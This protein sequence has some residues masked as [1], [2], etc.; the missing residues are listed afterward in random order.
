M[1]AD[2]A[3][4]EEG[5]QGHEHPSSGVDERGCGRDERP[6]KAGDGAGGEVA[7]ALDGGQEP[8]GRA[9]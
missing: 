2:A 3:G 4:D 7:E 8:E 6:E 9:A 5:D 1:P